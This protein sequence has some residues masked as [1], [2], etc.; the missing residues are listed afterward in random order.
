MQH[1]QKYPEGFRVP[2]GA[3]GKAFMQMIAI[4]QAMCAEA[5]PPKAQQGTDAGENA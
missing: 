3:I 2:I 1:D 4:T 5:H